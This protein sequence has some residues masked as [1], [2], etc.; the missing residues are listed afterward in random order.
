MKKI[1]VFII[2]LICIALFIGAWFYLDKDKEKNDILPNDQIDQG[3]LDIDPSE[4]IVF[5]VKKEPFSEFQKER[6]FD[7]FNN[8]KNIIEQNGDDYLSDDNY[9]AWLEIASVQKLIGDYDRAAQ[10][11]KWFNQAYAFNS[12]SP[13]NLGD[14]YKSFVIDKEESEKYY[15]MA[16]DRDTKDFQIYYGLYE[17]YRYRFEDS[18]KALQILYDGFENNQDDANFVNELTNYLLILDRR[19]EAEELVEGYIST[20]PEAFSI[21]EKLK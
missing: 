16:V 13:A 21:R 11:W 18:E 19:S 3:I 15:L 9:Y 14:L 7:R 2:I 10:L 1:Y 17:L 4:L 6:A 20:H 5:E 12:I 8:A